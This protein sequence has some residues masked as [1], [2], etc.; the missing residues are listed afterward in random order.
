[1]LF[2]SV[3]DLQARTVPVTDV[4]DPTAE[5]LSKSDITVQLHKYVGIILVEDMVEFTV[6]DPILTVANERAGRQA[7]LTMDRLCRAV[8][9]A[10]SNVYRS[11]G[12]AARTDIDTA[13]L[14]DDFWAAAR[15]LELANAEKF[16]KQINP[17]GGFNSNPVPASFW[18]VTHPMVAADIRQ[19]TN[20][21]PVQE[22]ASPGERHAYEIGA[23]KSGIRILSTTEAYSIADAGNDVGAT[24][25]KSTGGSKVDVYTSLVFAQD[26]YAAVTLDRHALQAI[27]KDKSNAGSKAD[28]YSSVAW[29]AIC[30]YKI[31]DDNRMIRIESGATA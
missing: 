4:V 29:K 1:M 16:T 14:D 30:A 2:R 8:V 6:E 25:L 12:V 13:I 11:D 3:P 7:G 10:G 28:L 9:N 21:I 18:M 15:E 17:A 19:L 24:G 23:H 31:L 26:A 27:I 22:Y 20:F 5:Q